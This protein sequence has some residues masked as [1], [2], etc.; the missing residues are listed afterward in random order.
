MSGYFIDFNN[1][2]ESVTPLTNGG[3]TNINYDIGQGGGYVNVGGIR[4]KGVEIALSNAINRQFGANVSLTLNRS[5]YTKSIPEHNVVGGNK[6]T[7]PPETM[8]SSSVFFKEGPFRASLTGKYTGERVGTLDNKEKAPGF[9]LF[10]LAL[11]YRKTF[12][13]G[14]ALGA[15]SVDVRVQNLLDKD[16]L[17]G[18]DGDGNATTGYYF[19]G[20]PRT[21]S[22]TFAVEF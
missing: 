14:A 20:A 7:G 5:E 18:L 17:A 13:P 19:I 11:G 9:T 4:S 22:I 16:Y 12:A 2:I 10:D 1:R 15:V 6:V 3:V 21:T 8:V